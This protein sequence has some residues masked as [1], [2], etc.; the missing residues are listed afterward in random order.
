MYRYLYFII[1][2]YK[3]EKYITAKKKYNDNL[4]EMHKR[5]IKTKTVVDKKNGFEIRLIGFDGKCKK[6]YNK[7]DI[8]KLFDDIEKMP[9]GKLRAK[10]GLSLYADYN[11]KTTLKGTGFKDAE[12]AKKTIDLIKDKNIV[13]QR[14]VIQ[15]MLNRAK[16]H[17]HQ[18]KGMKEAIK[19]F[20]KW[21]K[22]QK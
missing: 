7:L 22:D 11:P 1:P 20:E 15:T 5:F 2:G 4:Y 14:R 6:K 21:I 16:Y 17:P 19:I 18:T 12:T 8:K 10:K 3:D 9:M 13:Y